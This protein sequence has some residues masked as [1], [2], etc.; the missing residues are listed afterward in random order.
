[1]SLFF[2]VLDVVFASPFIIIFFVVVV[3]I[4]S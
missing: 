4:V 1:V 2:K 3:V